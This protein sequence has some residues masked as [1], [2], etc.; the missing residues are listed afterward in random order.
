MELRGVRGG[1]K[2]NLV[3]RL[4]KSFSLD[5]TG[6]RLVREADLRDVAEEEEEASFDIFLN[7]CQYQIG[8]TKLV[9][10]FTGE[11]ESWSYR[12]WEERTF[13]IRPFSGGLVGSE[14]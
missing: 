11:F 6:L 1:G 5:S 8:L 2:G 4:W 14:Y 9:G 12:R 7:S 10:V 3:K 13:T